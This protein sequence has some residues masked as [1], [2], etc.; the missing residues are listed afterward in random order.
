MV[1]AALHN[2]QSGYRREEWI[3][4]FEVLTYN[5]RC[6]HQQRWWSVKEVRK[7]HRKKKDGSAKMSIVVNERRRG[8][9]AQ[10]QRSVK[11]TAT[12]CDEDVYTD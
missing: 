8:T 2:H 7:S 12:M 3:V 10:W 9:L 6:L 5:R 1:I 4:L 11:Q